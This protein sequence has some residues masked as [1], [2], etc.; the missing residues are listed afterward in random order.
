MQSNR[1]PL[2]ALLLLMSVSLTLPSCGSGGSEQ[3]PAQPSPT[4]FGS[5]YLGGRQHMSFHGETVRAI[6]I[7]QTVVAETTL[8]DNGQFL[9]DARV[10]ADF[11]GRF[12]VGIAVT[13]KRGTQTVHLSRDLDLTQSKDGA[14]LVWIGPVATDRKST[15]LNSSH[16]S[17]SRMPS[18]A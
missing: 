18:S 6:S 2:A 7:D 17:V 4:L 1:R 16:S 12:E 13:T 5:L 15:R 3:P 14:P 10:L 9:F 8:R 11:V